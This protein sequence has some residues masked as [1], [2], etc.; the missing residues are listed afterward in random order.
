MKRF[1]L[2]LAIAAIVVDV[3]RAADQPGFDATKLP[4][5]SIW[6]GTFKFETKKDLISDELTL[7]ITKREGNKFVGEWHQHNKKEK[8]EPRYEMEGTISASNRVTITLTRQISGKGRDDKVG[9]M[10]ITGQLASDELAGTGVIPDT[11]TAMIWSV[12]LKK[13]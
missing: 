2:S 13:E 8:L 6:V 11:K 4:V 7:K 12:K 3:A 9:N 10:K 5:G 1:L